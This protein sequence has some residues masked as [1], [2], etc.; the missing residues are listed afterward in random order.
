MVKTITQH[1]KNQGSGNAK[2]GQ[3]QLKQIARVVMDAGE[4]HIEFTDNC[5]KTI[6]DELRGAKLS[7]NEAQRVLSRG[8]ILARKINNALVAWVKQRNEDSNTVGVCEVL[9]VV[10]INSIKVLSV[11]EEKVYESEDGG[12][13]PAFHDD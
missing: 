1:K 8:N 13:Q 12:Q 6:E 2:A 7:R 5:V 11:T 3:G 10:L 4:R 9:R